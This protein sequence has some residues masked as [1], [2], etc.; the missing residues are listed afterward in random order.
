MAAALA[1]HTLMHHLQSTAAAA[2]AQNSGC[3]AALQ[4]QQKSTSLHPG[5]LWQEI[6]QCCVILSFFLCG[7]FQGLL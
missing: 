3:K 6:N 2:P 4:Q 7:E 5:S 1:M